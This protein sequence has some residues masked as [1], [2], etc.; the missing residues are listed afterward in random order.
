[1]SANGY[2]Y[3]GE[4]KDDMAN[5]QGTL[6]SADG[7]KYVG[8]FKD[9]KFDGSGTVYGPNGSIRQSGV[10]KDNKLVLW[11]TPN[12]NVRRHECNTAF[13]TDAGGSCR[14]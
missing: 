3:V 5:G 12:Q 11:R 7:Y 13:C 10:W 4:F 8:E 2:K 9:G 14:R 1:M 6:T